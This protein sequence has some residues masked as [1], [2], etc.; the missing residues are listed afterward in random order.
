MTIYADQMFVENFIMNYI[1]LYMTAKLCGMEF[2]WYKLSIGAVI[3]AIYV[4]F[5]Y[6][7]L[8]YNEPLIFGKILLSIA[9]VYLSFFP[10][11]PKKFI[12]LLLY[13]YG[14]TFFI[15]GISFGLAYF[16]NVVTINEGGI[17]YVEEFPVVLVA[18]G[19]CFAFILGKYGIAFFYEYKRVKEILYKL[20]IG[21]FGKTIEINVIYDSGHSVREPFTNYPVAI[22]EK[23]AVG[24]I[25]LANIF[26]AT[27]LGNMEIPD[28]FKCKMRIVP[29][30]TVSSDKE[31]LIGFKA[32]E[33]SVI[34][35]DGE[36]AV[37]NVI[38]AICDRKLSKDGSYAGLIG[39]DLL[40]K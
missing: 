2:K 16:F 12:K 10:R 11:E 40:Y 18:I 31:I 37:N 39:K 13:F 9:I 33:C 6:V 23:A 27:K 5:S 3:G 24:D 26:D 21:L 36:K 32:D 25:F 19:S 38:I 7:F 15:G 28:E 35:D 34:K 29:I 22:V 30:S 4:I 1:I 8:F 20:R 14:I 17:L